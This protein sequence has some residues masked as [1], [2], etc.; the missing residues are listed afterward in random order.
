MAR[1]LPQS[2][3]ANEAEKSNPILDMAIANDPIT[4]DVLGWDW[5]GLQF[6]FGAGSSWPASVITFECSYDGATFGD[7]PTPATYN[8]IGPKDRVRVSG[9]LRV[10]ARVS[11]VAGAVGAVT[12]A[13]TARGSMDA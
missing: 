6:V 2:L 10:R 12:V 8:S 5:I 11:T 7:F 13:V 4:W 9:L 1:L 3:K